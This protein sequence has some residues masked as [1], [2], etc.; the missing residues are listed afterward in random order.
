MNKN[1]F[2]KNICYL[3]VNAKLTWADCITIVE[4]KLFKNSW[5]IHE[6]TDYLN[7]ETMI[8]FYYFV[9]NYLNYGNRG[10]LSTS[11]IKLLKSVWKQ[12]L[13]AT[14]IPNLEPVSQSSQLM[15]NL[16]IL[17]NYQLDIYNVLNVM[18]KLSNNSIT[19]I[20]HRNLHLILHDYHMQS[21]LYK[22]S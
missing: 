5:L 8:K 17:S 18:L 2:I 14:S 22:F 13:Q 6:A 9:Q 10:W 20:I 15:K 16:N 4:N 11:I 21:S 19:K 1:I 12:A 7:K 3:S